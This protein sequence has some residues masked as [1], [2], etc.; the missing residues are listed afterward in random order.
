MLWW[1]TPLFAWNILCCRILSHIGLPRNRKIHFFTVIFMQKMVITM[2]NHGSYPHFD[3][4]LHP[5]WN[6]TRFLGGPCYRSDYGASHRI[7]VETD[8][9]VKLFDQSG[10][11][12]AQDENDCN[13]LFFFFFRITPSR[14]LSC[15]W[16][17]PS[18]DQPGN[19]WNPCG[20]DHSIIRLIASVANPIS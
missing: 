20:N 13:V 15:L 1:T 17:R 9:W 18:S 14:N 4:S 19:R 8:L 16:Y 12:A 2:R 5:S 7:A 3:A 10:H 6:A 11:T